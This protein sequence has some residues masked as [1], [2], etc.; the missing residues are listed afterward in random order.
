MISIR[1]ANR[2]DISLLYSF[3]DSI[4]KKDDGYF[5]RSLDE[6]CDVLI[7]S[8]QGTPCGFCLL[9][10]APRYALYRTLEIPEIQDLNVIPQY[11]CQGVATA[12]IKWCEGSAKA[13]GKT[14][15]GIGVGL[16]RHYGPAQI[17]YAR[18]GFVPDGFGA[19]YDREAI[20]PYRLYRMDDDL[21]LMLIKELS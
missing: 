17:L 1:T 18:L 19:T 10:W 3:Y 2:S 7:A 14:M 5:E 12:L 11:R 8:I 6:K 15:I 4:G 21:S 9:N 20:E 16:T 13:K